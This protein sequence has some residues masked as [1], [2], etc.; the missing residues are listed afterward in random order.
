M[1]QHAHQ[2]LNVAIEDIRTEKEFS[3]VTFSGYKSVAAKTQLMKAMIAGEIEAAQYW[4]A[5]LL[6]AGHLM[7]IWE[8]C[9]LIASRYIHRANPRVISYL[10]LKLVKFRKLA[11]A[12]EFTADLE[13]RNDLDIRQIFGEIICVLSLSP[14][15]HSLDNTLV[16]IADY[17]GEKM[18]MKCR[19]PNTTYA[20]RVFRH[21]KAPA[22]TTA[23]TSASTT[24]SSLLSQSTIAAT[25][26]T[27]ATGDPPEI[28]VAL[29][30]FIY[31]ISEEGAN[32]QLACF[33]AEWICELDAQSRKRKLN[34]AILPRTKAPVDD[35]HM[36]D[37]VWILWEAMFD[38]IE[39]KRDTKQRSILHKLAHDALSIYTLR[40]TPSIK[41]RRRFLLY[42]LISYII[43]VP[44]IE[45]SLVYQTNIVAS[46]CGK[47]GAIYNQLK[48][49]EVRTLGSRMVEGEGGGDISHA[50]LVPLPSYLPQPEAPISVLPLRPPMP[51]S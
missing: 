1:I 39:R 48:R 36:D 3:G 35:R 17:D 51:T 47:I 18:A 14:K 19:A 24:A 15:Q 45:R 12:G 5:E 6:S 23:S 8:T 43:E 26:V 37:P 22:S 7:M 30:E 25:D 21:G 32:L 28:Y 16:K 2:R 38:V 20:D 4:A 10:A 9:F 13:M 49:H 46:I 29:N 31:S 27:R 50:E 41:K 40:Y 34:L 42:M 33:W 44:S 11:R